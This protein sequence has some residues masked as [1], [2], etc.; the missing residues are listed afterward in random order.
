VRAHCF[1]PDSTGID[2]LTVRGFH[3]S[4]AATQW[5]PPTAEQQGLIGTN[6]SR[7]WIIE[8]NVISNSK[9]AGLTLGKYGDEFDNTSAST[10]SGYIETVRRALDKGWSREAVGSHLVRNNTI[11]DCGQVGICGSLGAIFSTIEHNDIRNIWTKR[12][13]DGPETA[14]IKIHAAIDMLITGNRVVNCGRGIWLDWMAQGARVSGNLCYRNDLQDFYSEV[15]HGPYLV[16]NNLFL[17]LCSVWEMAQG[18]AYAHNL[19]AGKLNMS[20]HHRETPFMEPHSTHIA[21]FQEQKAGDYRF[22]NNVFVAGCPLNADQADPQ[23]K[24]RLQYGKETFGLG[25]FE[26]SAFPT[27]S[28]GNV[29]VNGALPLSGDSTG[30]ELVFDPQMM[31]EERQDGIYLRLIMDDGWVSMKNGQI[32]SELLGKAKV[33]DQPYTLPDGDPVIIDSDYLGEGRSRCHPTAGP[34]EHQ[35]K[36]SRSFRVW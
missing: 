15:N 13:F 9:C 36:G 17:S 20:P 21:G 25:A 33:P 23:Q 3:M 11:S 5:A 31:L 2:Y 1:Y 4:Q 28:A 29:Y 22:F 27:F 26:N 12:Q 34:F 10:A 35:G 24:T 19:M 30:V 8:E 7:G 14:G 18:G 32:T 6:W 16:D